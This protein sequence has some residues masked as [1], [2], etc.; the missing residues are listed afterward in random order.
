MTYIHNR[1]PAV[2]PPKK[3]RKTWGP[4]SEDALRMAMSLVAKKE[5]K[6]MSVYQD[7]RDNNGK[8]GPVNRSMSQIT[9]HVLNVITEAGERGASRNAIR[10]EVSL[11]PNTLEEVAKGLEA[12]G[13]IK[14]REVGRYVFFIA[15]TK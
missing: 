2:L 15:V 8:R 14:R 6:A 12:K 13:Q 11:N 9:S 1:T 5:N 7:K 3:A 4:M 10:R